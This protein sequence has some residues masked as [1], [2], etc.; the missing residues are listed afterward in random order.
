MD[1]REWTNNMACDYYDSSYCNTAP[2]VGGNPPTVKNAFFGE[3]II[4]KKFKITDKSVTYTVKAG[5]GDSKIVASILK[6]A[7]DCEKSF[8]QAEV[9]KQR[10]GR[11]WYDPGDVI[12]FKY[13]GKEVVGQ[14]IKFEFLEKL[15][16]G[17]KVY[18]VVETE[19]LRGKKVAANM[20]Q[21]ADAVL[22]AK[23]KEIPVLDGENETAY[24]E[25]EVGEFASSSDYTN[26]DDYLDFAIKEITIRPKSDEDYD[27]WA[28]KI[29]DSVNKYSKHCLLI[30]AHSPNPDIEDTMVSYHGKNDD[31]TGEYPNVWLDFDDKWFKVTPPCFCYSDFTE[32]EVK[33]LIST[34]RKVDKYK[35]RALFY[36]SNCPLPDNH[37]TYAAF[38]R[39]VNAAMN[40]YAIDTC[41]RKAHFFAQ[42]YWEAD[43]CKTTMEYASGNGYNPGKHSNAKK[44]KNTVAGDG[45]RYKGR[46]LMQ[47]TW[48][49][50]YEDY[51]QW[52]V[53][54]DAATL[55]SKT[56]ADITFDKL[57][58][59]TKTYNELI[60]NDIFFAL[61][62]A[63]WY[64]EF[65]RIHD[66]NNINHYC[67]YGDKHIDFISKLVNGGANGKSERKD[68]YEKMRDLVFKLKDNCASYEDILK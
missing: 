67:D 10:S 48:R 65:G 1:F 39:E 17:K 13:K 19:N 22:A 41:I 5:Q 51:F 50:N 53:D 56:A 59:R 27:E 23:G 26:K 68:Y 28:D 7:P 35:S 52:M 14:T 38:T 61:D 46:G 60:A 54:N 40:K 42:I 58:D 33:E 9:K 25:M 32:D 11:K 21:G 66:G 18:V 45:P 29:K 20:Q 30:D 31:D 34:M 16:L 44:M 24:I 63:G 36:A 37:K 62:S 55:K 4:K 47:L 3:A 12:T 43:R 49:S 15:R 57:M 6:E 8:A 2:G 64:W